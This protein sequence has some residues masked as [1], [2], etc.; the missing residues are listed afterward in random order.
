MKENIKRKVAW[1]KGVSMTEVT[2]KRISKSLKGRT[3]WNK[4]KKMS[5]IIKIKIKEST[6][7]RTPWNK[8]R[9]WSVK[10][11]KKISKTKLAPEIK[12][13]NLYNTI[14]LHFKSNFREIDTFIIEE[15]PSIHIRVSNRGRETLPTYIRHCIGH[16]EHGKYKREELIYSI[17][18]LAILSKKLLSLVKVNR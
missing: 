6:K 5:P 7:G 2:K 4:G 18:I 13:I 16:P 10:V 3:P 17:N 12:F 1:N 14:S 9:N 15:V 8:G 11:K